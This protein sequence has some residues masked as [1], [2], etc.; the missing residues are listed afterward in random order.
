[1]DTGFHFRFTQKDANRLL[2]A[3][4]I[5][6]LCLTIIFFMN[7]QL[8]M[9]PHF[10]RLFHFDRE[11][12][13]PTWFS[14]LQLFSIGIL[15][16]FSPNW[17]KRHLISAPSVLLFIG[18]GFIFLSMDEAA[19][20]HEKITGTLMHIE[21]VPRFKGNHGIWI[22]V[23]SSI[24]VFITIMSFRTIKSLFKA[25][26]RQI[27]FIFSGFIILLIGGVGLEIINYL[28]LGDFK[29]SLLYIIEV[30]LEEFFEMLGASLILYGTIS[31]AISGHQSLEKKKK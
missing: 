31:C 1:M 27:I 13:I 24:A 4:I 17:P 21:W 14:S 26:P 12:T 5:F 8:H 16:L 11:T 30:G 29:K 2:F 9:H 28:Y 10:E 3:L 18:M 6:E 19:G 23:Y 25:Y 15:F 20:F 7:T 22:P